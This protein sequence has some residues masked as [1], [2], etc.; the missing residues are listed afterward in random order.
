MNAINVFSILSLI[1]VF[2]V[3]CAPSSVEPSSTEPGTVPNRDENV[4]PADSPATSMPELLSGETPQGFFD[5]IVN[6]MIS[7]SGGDRSA[8]RVLKSEAV[9]WGDGSLG[10]PQPGMMYTQ[11]IV[12]GYH[13]ILAVGEE[14]YDYRLTERGTFVLCQS[15]TSLDLSGETPTE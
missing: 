8:V 13:V 15:P 10:C 1:A 2:L 4:P 12:S 5:A 3:G 11:A 14:T 6:D 7:R 9:E